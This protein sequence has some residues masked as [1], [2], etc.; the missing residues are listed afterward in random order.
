M[1]EIRASG[2]LRVVHVIDSLAGSGGAENRL[3]DEV[4]AMGDRFDQTVVRLFERDFLDE[5]LREVGVPVVPPVH[6]RRA[7]GPGRSSGTGWRACCCAPTSST[8]RCSPA[9]SWASLAGARVGVPVVSTFN[10]TGDA[11]LQRRLQPGVASWKGRVM[12]AV[13]RWPG[14][15]TCTTALSASTPA[16]PTAP[17]SACPGGRHGGS[18]GR[19]G[20]GSGARRRAGGGHRGRRGGRAR[21]A[22]RVRAAR[23]RPPVRQR[24]PAGA[25]EGPPPAG[26]SV[27]AG[28]GPAARRAWPSPAPT[29]WPGPRSGTRSSGRG[30]ARPCRC[31]A[32]GPTPAPRVAAAHV[33]AFSSMSEGLPAPWSRRSC[34][35]RRWRRS[36]SCRWPS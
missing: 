29:A 27:R 7:G 5:R 3:V 4:V 9:T 31:W 35:A 19:V 28:G 23:G 17:R 33:F 8:P 12:Q 1:D 21:G 36:P 32:S 24:R 26:R 30:W 25:R 16:A 10:R 6:G 11:E 14:G 22:G 15:A 34:W 2:R 20:R 13:G 18:P